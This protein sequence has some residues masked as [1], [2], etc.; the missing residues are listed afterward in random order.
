MRSVEAV[1]LP[2][3]NDLLEAQLSAAHLLRLPC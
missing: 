1:L 2:A 3:H